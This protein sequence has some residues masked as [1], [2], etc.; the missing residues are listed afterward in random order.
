MSAAGHTTC[1]YCNDVTYGIHKPGRTSGALFEFF[2]YTMSLDERER[3]TL[4]MMG[5]WG[6]NRR[7]HEEAYHYLMTTFKRRSQFLEQL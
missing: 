3:I 4:L 5:G 1:K 7:S 2:N 6:N